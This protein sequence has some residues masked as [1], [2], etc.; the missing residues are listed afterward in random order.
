MNI[1]RAPT[2]RYETFPLNAAMPRTI[3]GRWL[4]FTIGPA[5]GMVL[6]ALTVLA[7]HSHPSASADGILVLG[8]A[9]VVSTLIPLV[10]R[11]GETIHLFDDHLVYRSAARERHEV[12]YA[13]VRSMGIEAARTHG[14]VPRTVYGLRFTAATS[15][16]TTII[17]MAAF[18]VADLSAV[19]AV[20]ASHAPKAALDS[21]VLLLR[22]GEWKP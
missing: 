9:S 19:V 3:R 20:V 18:R 11:W 8:V 12:V 1:R 17:P 6:V 10:L 7:V 14:I 15:R 22:R 21:S 13:A 16:Q 5:I 2:R 4:P